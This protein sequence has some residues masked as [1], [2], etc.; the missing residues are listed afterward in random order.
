LG[1]WLI[2]YNLDIM[3]TAFLTMFLIS[4]LLALLSCEEET[5]EVPQLNGVWVEQKDKLD[6]IYFETG[7]KLFTL[8]RGKE[9]KNGH[10]LPKFGSGAYIYKLKVDSISL[11]NKL[12]SCYC[13]DDYYFKA[14]EGALKIGAF[15]DE[16]FSGQEIRT[17]IKQ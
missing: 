2:I 12:S 10:L 9:M 5:V 15:Y 13:F 8:Q 14:E 17:F 7:E 16:N 11:Y 4:S 6:T 3:K 1:N